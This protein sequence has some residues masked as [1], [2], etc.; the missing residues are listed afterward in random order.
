MGIF[1]LAYNGHIT[2]AYHVHTAKHSN[3]HSHHMIFYDEF[4]LLS[5]REHQ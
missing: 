1:W 4:N 3:S 5:Y 2:F